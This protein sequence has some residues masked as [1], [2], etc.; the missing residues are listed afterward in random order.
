MEAEIVCPRSL[1]APGIA[2]RYLAHV[3][4]P[5]DKVGAHRIVARMATGGMAT[6]FLAQREGQEGP[7]SY[8]IIKAIH[9]QLSSDQ[10]FRAMF[11]DEARLT[12]RIRHANVVTAG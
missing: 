6:V 8:V 9:R 7:S 3:F 5:G 11:L 10:A 2:P 1:L 4:T 12:Q